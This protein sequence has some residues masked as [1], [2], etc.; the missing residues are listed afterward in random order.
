MIRQ[1]RFFVKPKTISTRNLSLFCYI[2]M[3]FSLMF[4]Q[5]LCVAKYFFTNRTKRWLN[6]PFLLEIMMLHKLMICQLLFCQICLIT[7][8][9]FS[10]IYFS[11][12]TLVIVPSMFILQTFVTDG[13]AKSVATSSVSLELDIFLIYFI[14]LSFKLNRSICYLRF[15]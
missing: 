9:A 7:K 14:S 10:I 11:F 12:L 13:A 3:C 8:L 15:F 4:P 6:N 2:F 5:I 1:K